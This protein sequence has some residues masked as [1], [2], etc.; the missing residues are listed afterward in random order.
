MHDAGQPGSDSLSGWLIM[1]IPKGFFL[2]EDTGMIFGFAEASPDIS[3]MGMADLQ[4]SA[5]AVIL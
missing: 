4:Q 3:F 5:A 1:T 2:E